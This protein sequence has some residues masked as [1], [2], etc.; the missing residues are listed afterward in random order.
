MCV[1]GI[2]HTLRV[3][4]RPSMFDCLTMESVCRTLSPKSAGERVVNLLTSSSPHPQPGQ[5]LIYRLIYT[6][7]YVF[8]HPLCEATNLTS[9]GTLFY[10]KF[11]CIFKLATPPLSLFWLWKSRTNAHHRPHMLV[12]LVETRGTP[13]SLPL[14]R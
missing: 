7:L 13:R 11:N 6:G 3:A 1:V 10:C 4:I 8:S 14:L 5:V 9:D 12:E 2:P